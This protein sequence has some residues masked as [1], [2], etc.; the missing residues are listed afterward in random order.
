MKLGSISVFH[1]DGFDDDP[2]YEPQPITWKPKTIKSIDGTIDERIKKLEAA[3]AILTNEVAQ[4]KE[5][6]K[7]A[8]NVSKKEVSNKERR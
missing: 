4:L 7:G 3:V 5:K 2:S 1:S 8:A 6:L